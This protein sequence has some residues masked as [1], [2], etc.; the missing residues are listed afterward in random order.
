MTQQP[1]ADD[2]SIVYRWSCPLCSESNQ[3]V[4]NDYKARRTAQ[5]DLKSHIR[6]TSDGTHEGKG[7]VPPEFDEN[8]HRLND[9]VELERLVPEE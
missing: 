9:C 2:A 1:G 8:P 5:N 7:E 4:A 6:N 3:A